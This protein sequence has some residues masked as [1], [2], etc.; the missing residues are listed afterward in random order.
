MATARHEVR[1]LGVRANRLVARDVWDH[2]LIGK[3]VQHS[4]IAL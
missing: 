1:E 2:K 4:S 3:V